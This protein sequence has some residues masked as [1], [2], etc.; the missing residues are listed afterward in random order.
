MRVKVHVGGLNNLKA[1]VHE[2]AYFVFRI[3]YARHI[4]PTLARRTVNFSKVN[5]ERSEDVPCGDI[6]GVGSWCAAAE[7]RCD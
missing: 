5:S 1:W 4:L 3:K 6:F 2:A 7:T